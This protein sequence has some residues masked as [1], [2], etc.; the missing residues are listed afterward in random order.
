M[1]TFVYIY[2]YIYILFSYYTYHYIFIGIRENIKNRKVNADIDATV[3]IYEKYLNIA[4]FLVILSILS[5]NKI[6]YL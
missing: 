4:S 3:C 6:V 1:R 5:N 2:I